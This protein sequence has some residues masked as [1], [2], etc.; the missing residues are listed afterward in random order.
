MST[1]LG[2]PSLYSQQLADIICDRLKRGD[3]LR[4]ICEDEN[5]P[6]ESTVRAWALDNR[7]GFYP[8]YA[9]ARQIQAERLADELLTIADSSS[10][11]EYN[12]ARLRVD[13][14][15][16]ILSKVL[17]KV[18]GDAMQ[19]RHADADGNQLKVEVTRVS[20]RKPRVIDVTPTPA[21]L[22]PADPPADE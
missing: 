3:S 10:P 17:P 15:K 7:E 13:T 14:R 9:R 19:L 11:E 2:R 4:K 18:Y 16:W 8:Q 5:L 1:A 22:P 20:P 12:V 21:A 6:D